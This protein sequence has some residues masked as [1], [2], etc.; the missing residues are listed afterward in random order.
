MEVPPGEIFGL[1][2]PNGAGK[3]S[4]FRVLATLMEPTYGEVKPGGDRHP[5]APA[6]SGAT[7]DGIHAGSR[8]GAVG[9]QGVGVS[10]SLRRSPWPGQ[11][12]RSGASGSTSASGEVALTDK[13]EVFARP[14]RAARPSGWC[15]PKRCCT[16]RGC[17]ILDEPASGM[18][19]LSRRNLRLALRTL[20]DGGDHGFRQLAHPQRTGG[21]VFLPLCHEPRP[22]ARRPARW[23]TCGGC[24]AGPNGR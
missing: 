3:T 17:M 8:A 1:V 16:G 14:S 19:P 20:A 23:R 6:R 9:P 5:R 12:G 18:D 4:T 21:N 22:P 7:G 13:R 11:R 2:G 24:S 15:W 10:R